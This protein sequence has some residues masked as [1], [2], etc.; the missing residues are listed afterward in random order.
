MPNLGDRFQ[1]LKYAS[2]T[3]QFDTILGQDLPLGQHFDVVYGAKSM[4]LVVAV[5]EPSA[6]S[7]LTVAGLMALRRTRK[8]S[9]QQ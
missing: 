9:R 4:E 8:H 1:V 6:L 2:Y 3:G 5:P 7:L